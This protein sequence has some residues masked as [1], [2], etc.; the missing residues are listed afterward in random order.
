M[1]CQGLVKSIVAIVVGVSLAAVGLTSG[2]A[3]AQEKSGTIGVS[4][5][6][7]KGPWFTPVLYGIS[8]EAKK[9]GYNVNIQDA[10]GYANVDK[11]VT[12]LFPI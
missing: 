4:M 7:I 11:Q 2:G 12:Q 8:D 10:G 1:K 3:L 5:P 6:N 9:L